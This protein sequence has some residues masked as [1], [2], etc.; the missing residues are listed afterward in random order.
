MEWNGRYRDSL[1]R[2]VR[3]DPGIAGEVASRIAGSSDLYQANL[4]LPINSINFITCHD[5]L[6]LQDLVSYEHKRNQANGENNRDG[7]NNNLSW[8]CGVEGES[9]DP[10]VIAL[11]KRQAKNFLSLL[12]LSQGIPML[13][14]GDEV[15]RTQGGNNNVWCQDNATGWLD[16]SLVD[17][18]A[19]MLRFVRELIALRK[20]HPSLQ[21]RRFLS[22]QPRSGSELADISWQGPDGESPQW[23]DP[24]SRSLGFTLARTEAGEE[25]LQVLMN[26]SD[27]P[28]TFVLR[29]SVGRTWYVALDTARP[30]P[31]EI[32]SKDEQNRSA[33]DRYQV[34]A[35]SLVVL[36][37]R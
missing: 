6:S 27:E 11:R 22:G 10:Q 37:S 5:G 20:R 30:A 4:R 12:F 15:L 23:D 24:D 26:M 21:R 32:A 17:R 29:E 31:Q 13:L 1:R 7:C 3:G 19:D 28:G 36:E 2:F 34:A 14:A 33:Q 8:N 16:W 9:D 35:R 18:N 25:D